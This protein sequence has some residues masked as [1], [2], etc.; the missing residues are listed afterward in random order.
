MFEWKDVEN[1]KVRDIST[2]L[3]YTGTSLPI[4]VSIK[5]QP[6]R[7]RD[8]YESRIELYNTVDCSLIFEKTEEDDDFDEL[9]KTSVGLVFVKMFYW[10]KEFGEQ[11]GYS[12]DYI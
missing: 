5:I 6:N 10:V 7:N 11:L 9:K 12:V 4:E 2:S 8:K 1:E 3:T